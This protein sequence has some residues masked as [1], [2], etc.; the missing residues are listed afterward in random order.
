MSPGRCCQTHGPITVQPRREYHACL[1]SVN[2]YKVC[3]ACDRAASS[4]A[5]HSAAPIPRR[6]KCEPTNT[7]PSQGVRSSRPSRSCTR[8]AA[9]PRSCPFACATHAIGNLSRFMCVFSFL[10]RASGVSS[11]KNRAPLLE[12]PLRQLRD[13]FRVLNQVANPNSTHINSMF[14]LTRIGRIFGLFK[15]KAQFL[16]LIRL[17]F[18]GENRRIG[19]MSV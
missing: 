4:T 18:A 12:E 9:V 14:G 15:R 5:A 8:R 2:K 16:R 19:G 13:V 17:E 6:R 11:P 7:P 1:S 3:I 10:I